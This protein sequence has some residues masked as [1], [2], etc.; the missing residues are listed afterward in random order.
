MPLAVSAPPGD[1]LIAIGA[2]LAPGTLLAAYRNGLFPMP[3]DPS[4]RKSRIAW[5]SPDPRGILPLDRLRVSRSLRRSLTRYEVTMN[6]D[7]AGVVR[8]CADRTRPGRWITDEIIDATI[9]DLVAGWEGAEAREGV[10]AF[11]EKRKPSW[12]A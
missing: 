10:A 11:F 5:Y 9:A 3:V 7:F 6:R 2:D 12:S 8:G 1:D 4:R